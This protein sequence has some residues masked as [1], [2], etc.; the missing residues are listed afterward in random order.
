MSFI[1]AGYHGQNL[2]TWSE[3][4]SDWHSRAVELANHL[5]LRAEENG[6]TAIKIGQ[7]MRNREKELIDVLWKTHWQKETIS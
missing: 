5:V 4:Y 2:D 1:I 3:D 7:E 6:W